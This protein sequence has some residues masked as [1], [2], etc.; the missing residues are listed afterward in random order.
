MDNE[1]KEDFLTS[2]IISGMDNT[3]VNEYDFENTE[4]EHIVNNDPFVIY[5]KTNSP[6]LVEHAGNDYIIQVG[7]V[8][9]VQT[10]LYQEEER[11]HDIDMGRIISYERI[12]TLNIP[13]GYRAAGLDD[14]VIDFEL[15]TDNGLSAIFK[16]S[17]A[18]KDNQVILTVHEWYKDVQIDKKYYPEFRKVINAAADY[19]KVVVILEPKDQ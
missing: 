16:S 1:Q 12:I 17:Y 7:K 6:D 9:G 14:T 13:D 2:V 5:L 10:E 4:S 15:N 18:V 3:R 8:L 19:N 11:M